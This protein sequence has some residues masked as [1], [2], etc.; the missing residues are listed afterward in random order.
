MRAASP[1][2]S[3]VGGGGGGGDSMT[4]SVAVWSDSSAVAEWP[5]PGSAPTSG[6]MVSTASSSGLVPGDWD[7]L[8]ES[9]MEATTAAR[10]R[11]WLLARERLSD[12]GLLIRHRLGDLDHRKLN[13]PGFRHPTDV[14]ARAR[15]EGRGCRLLADSC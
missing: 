11:E 14:V 6:D 12:M 15:E 9:M 10:L 4:M 5:V 1:S 7:P 8:S 13:D 3:D 2:V